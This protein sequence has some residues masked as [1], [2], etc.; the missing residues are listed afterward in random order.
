MEVESLRGRILGSNPRSMRH[1]VSVTLRS[2]GT[3]EMQT[4]RNRATGGRRNPGRQI[5]T[6]NRR[7][8]HSTNRKAI[9]LPAP[10]RTLPPTDEAK[11]LCDASRARTGGPSRATARRD[12]ARETGR[13]LAAILP[14]HVFER[15]K[16]EVQWEHPLRS[17]PKC[18]LS[19]MAWRFP[20]RTPNP[21]RFGAQA[22]PSHPACPRAALA[23]G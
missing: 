7:F 8:R 10:R 21:G 18:L 9:F 13:M 20:E 1:G 14:A 3:C 23:R 11:S 17:W 5:R 15:G 4:L 19:K 2:W 22:V 12:A 6:T 16:R